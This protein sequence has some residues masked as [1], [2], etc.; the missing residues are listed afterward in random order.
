MIEAKFDNERNMIYPNIGD[1]EIKSFIFE[2]SGLSLI[3]EDMHR[4]VYNFSFD[5]VEFFSAAADSCYLIV[6]EFKC[7]L[8]SGD[9]TFND[10]IFN[11]IEY[12]HKVDPN[13]EGFIYEIVPL[14]GAHIVIACKDMC[15]ITS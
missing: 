3:I 12:K 13:F 2:R 5:D 9:M 1:A 14:S 11:F 8:I 6:S 7:H 10:S 15:V 4:V